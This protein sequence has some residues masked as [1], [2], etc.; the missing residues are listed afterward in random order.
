MSSGLV[1]GLRVPAPP[2]WIWIALVAALVVAAVLAI[3]VEFRVHFRYVGLAA[4]EMI[5]FELGR[6]KG[7][8]IWRA[9]VSLGDLARTEAGRALGTLM[10]REP[11]RG[12]GRRRTAIVLA[13][14]RR[15]RWRRLAWRT[16][17]GFSDAASTAL[18]AGT[19]W[20]VKGNLAALARS[21]LR[22]APGLPE[23]L[24]VPDFAEPGL[25]S[26]LEGI[27]VLRA[28]HIM[29]ALP[30]LAL[31]AWRESTTQSGGGSSGRA[32]HPRLD[33]DRY[34]EHPGDGRRQHHR[35]RS[36]GSAGR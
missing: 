25:E 8:G 13:L 10:G 3:P 21:N 27:G 15:A 28:G 19:L 20:A 2:G 7:P 35:R 17:L 5:V 4:G 33:E 32:P 34:G 12:G 6:R 31:G 24:V 30:E 1:S 29:L 36:G 16:R 26:S 9:S 11:V 14:A 23:F 18:V 22:L